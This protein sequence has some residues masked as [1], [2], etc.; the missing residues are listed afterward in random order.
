MMISQR[1]YIRVRGHGLGPDRARGAGRRAPAHELRRDGRRAAPQHRGQRGAPARGLGPLWGRAGPSGA[2]AGPVGPSAAPARAR[3][4]GPFGARRIGPFRARRRPLEHAPARARRA[5]RARPGR[6]RRIGPF[7]ARRPREVP[8]AR[9]A[10][11]RPAGR[12]ENTRP[13]RAGPHAHGMR[14][15]GATRGA[16]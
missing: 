16:A 5:R 1:G 14:G 8:R 12:R 4:M 6:R 2:A 15:P 9:R 13:P 10:A 7:G 3:R 11:H